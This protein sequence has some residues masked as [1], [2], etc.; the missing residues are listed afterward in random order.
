[1]FSPV[2][3]VL[4]ICAYVALLFLIAR[5]SERTTHGKRLANHPAVYALGLAVYCTTWTYY[6]SVGN[7]SKGGMSFLPVYLGPTL[8]L[9]FGG[10]LLQRLI[11]LKNKHHITSLADFISARFAKSQ[12]VAALVTVIMAVGILPYIAI[13]LK[14]VAGTFDLITAAP[15]GTL[16]PFAPWFNPLVV[17]MMIVFTIVLGIR[18][19]DPTERHPGMVVS[20]AAESIVKLSAFLA[21]GVFITGAAFGGFG[22]FLDHL[23]SLPPDVLPLM[24]ATS[25]TQV[26][27]WVTVCVL[28]MAAFS[29]LPRQFHVGV[30]ESSDPNHARLAQ[31]LT[32]LYLL[33]INI[34]VIPIALGGKLLSPGTSADQLVLSLPIHQGQQA[35]SL[36]V[37]VGGFSAAIGMIMIEGMTL[38]TMISNHL[39]LPLSDLSPRLT[40]LRRRLLPIRW[41]AAAFVISSGYLFQVTVGKSYMLVAIGL[42]SFAAAAFV[43]PVAV[44]GLFWR[45][46]N[47]AG[48][49]LGLSLGFSAWLYTLFLPTLARSGWLPSTFLTHGPGHISWLRPEALFGWS[50]LPTLPHGSLWCIGLSIFGFTIGSILWPSSAQERRM[51]NDFLDIDE[52]LSS[53]VASQATHDTPSLLAKTSDTLSQFFSPQELALQTALCFS[54]AGLSPDAPSLSAIDH[55]R[56]YQVV[57]RTLSGVCGAAM[58]HG[59]MRRLWGD[60]D[61]QDARVLTRAF[62]RALAH[63][64]L[65][66]DELRQRINFQQERDALLSEQFEQLQAKIS[67][68]DAEIAERKK[69][70]AALTDARDQLEVRVEERTLELA[71]ANKNI[72]VVLDHVVFGFLI[73]D[74]SLHIQ[75]GYTTSCHALFDHPDDL[76]G[77]CL[78]DLLPWTSPDQRL[79]HQLALEQVFDD[80]LPTEASLSNVAQRFPMPSHKLLRVEPRAVRDPD[81][82]IS[83]LL[84]TLSDITDLE[85][86]QRESVQHRVLINILR[87]K[88]AFK[89]FLTYARAQLLLASSDLQRGADAH[90]RRVLHTLKGGTA[91][92]GLSSIADLIH[93]IEALDPL[94]TS[95]I[96]TVQDSLRAFLS[97]HASIL[98]IPDDSS[99]SF[100]LS[101]SQIQ[102]LSDL[103]DRFPPPL[104][105]ALRAWIASAT[106]SPAADLIGP[107][108]VLARDL[109]NRLDKDIQFGIVGADLPVDPDRVRD[110]FAQIPHLLRNAI[111]H[112]I[113]PRSERLS[114]SKPS[115]GVITLRVAANPTTYALRVEDDGRGINPAALRDRAL[116]L[117]ILTPPQAAALSPAD[118]LRLIFHPKLSTSTTVSDISGRGVGLAAVLHAVESLGG[119]AAIDS[120]PQQGTRITLTIPRDAPTSA[121]ASASAPTTPS[122]NPGIKKPTAP[123]RPTS[124]TPKAPR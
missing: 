24:N 85:R 119:S 111:D 49:L 4:I 31:W 104:A 10:H 45:Q 92:Y 47:R 90:A 70:E 116:S 15:D 44:L 16:S 56:L 109:A 103:A 52:D 121:P 34:F 78:L 98:D 66:P 28:S 82:H 39:I 7:A 11:R 30:V 112:G 93:D 46:G 58:A 32:P 42:V 118:L 124:P 83:G 37:F 117:G 122:A 48:A 54:S 62:A 23:A 18:H 64:R 65:S 110:L 73:I 113:E 102:A 123:P 59:I 25:P 72:R 20:L 41:L 95:H 33:F 36:A 89:G 76:S 2:I 75:E 40:W 71:T 74:P 51:V 107:V 17:V 96:Q 94:T 43:A 101:R 68:R 8:V 100:T 38:A 84:M 29:T 91:A 14:S 88:E 80:F 63:L 50:R 79:E 99:P 13:Q 5:W 81:G 9:I 120:T 69:A 114:S 86:A 1:M 77:L 87:Q 19:L 61:R 57:E 106:L 3:V 35:L 27:S 108:D 12:A 6:G 22:G 53:Q 97:D 21:A 67:E 26:L 115:Q 105:A 60:L 55:A